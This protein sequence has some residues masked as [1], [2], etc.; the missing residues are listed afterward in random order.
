MTSNGKDRTGLTR[1][2]P[3]QN[4]NKHHTPGIFKKKSYFLLYQFSLITILLYTY[5]LFTILLY[6]YSLFS[7]LIYNFHLSYFLFFMI[8]PGVWCL[9]WFWLG[10]ILVRPV[11]RARLVSFA[12]CTLLACFSVRSVIEWF[13]KLVSLT[14]RTMESMHS[15]SYCHIPFERC[16]CHECHL[17][18]S[19]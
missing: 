1:N 6:T 8:I 9:L 2:N 7:I 15:L 4:H 19:L 13:S 17:A 10:L 3:N 16:F 18:Q 11:R 12:F 14:K 5:A